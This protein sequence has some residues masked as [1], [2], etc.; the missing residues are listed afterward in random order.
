[1]E[2]RQDIFD[3][4]LLWR[5]LTFIENHEFA[6]CLL[7]EPLNKWEAESN[8]SVGIGADKASD[9]AFVYSFQNGDKLSP[10]KIE[11]ASNWTLDKK[12]LLA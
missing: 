5:E 6:A 4:F 8:G 3:E 11:S 2:D 7:A 10:P 1:M 9:I 12:Q